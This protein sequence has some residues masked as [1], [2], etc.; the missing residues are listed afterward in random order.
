MKQRSDETVNVLF[1]HPMY[2]ADFCQKLQRHRMG[3]VGSTL[4]FRGRNRLLFLAKMCTSCKK[5]EI[6][7]GGRNASD[8][9][10]TELEYVFYFQDG[11]Q[12]NRQ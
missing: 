10:K 1:G 9:A 7:H 4:S 6:M 11:R 12:N 8:T 3:I 5:H 2:A